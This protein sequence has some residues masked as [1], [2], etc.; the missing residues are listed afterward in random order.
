MSRALFS[1][2]LLVFP[3][4]AAASFDA[5]GVVIGAAESEV[6]KR[7]PTAHCKPLEWSTSAADRRCDDAKVAF[8]GAEARVTFYLKRNMVE[9]FEVRFASRDAE[10]LVA[11]LKGRYGKPAAEAREKI[12]RRGKPPRELYKVRWESGA[13]RAVLVAPKDEKRASLS[14]SRGDFEEEIYRVR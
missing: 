14:V 3:L 1:F 8:A 6:M 7:F 5:N 2:V 12:E 9:A 4:H 13:Q 10:R 11:E